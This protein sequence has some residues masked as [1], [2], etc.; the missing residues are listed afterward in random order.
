M[1]WQDRTGDVIKA[2]AR[3]VAKA[4]GCLLKLALMCAELPRHFSMF[5]H[6]AAIVPTLFTKPQDH[7]E[8]SLLTVSNVSNGSFANYI[9]GMNSALQKSKKRSMPYLGNL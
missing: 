2:L 6:T 9:Q 1:P 5:H 7:A 4:T 8:F 3:Y